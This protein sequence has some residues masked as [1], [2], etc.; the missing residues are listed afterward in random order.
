ML[1]NET[2]EFTRRGLTRLAAGAAAPLQAAATQ[3]RFTC[4]GPPGHAVDAFAPD[5]SD[6]AGCAV[7]VE[8]PL[9]TA[10]RSV[11][12]MDVAAAASTTGLRKKSG[13]S[14][15]TSAAACAGTGIFA[16]TLGGLVEL[17]LDATSTTVGRKNTPV[18][19]RSMMMSARDF[20]GW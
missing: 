15:C 2:L 19:G 20:D 6:P 16:L 3:V 1:A 7:A 5:G 10:V 4:R 14:D 12:G 9:I 11:P 13:W 18:V 8:G 17:A